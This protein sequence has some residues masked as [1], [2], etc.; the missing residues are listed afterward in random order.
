[1]DGICFSSLKGLGLAHDKIFALNTLA[2]QGG[3]RFHAKPP[4]GP[5]LH[6][7]ESR[8]YLRCCNGF[9]LTM[10]VLRRANK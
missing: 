4:R 6:E 9:I 1:M 2:R 8:E 10:P 5:I 3:G 7:R